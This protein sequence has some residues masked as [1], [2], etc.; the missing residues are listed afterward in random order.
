MTVLATA[1]LD[2]STLDDEA[3]YAFLRLLAPAGAE[4]TYR[5]VRNPYRVRRTRR[6]C[7]GR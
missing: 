2:G 4:T 6:L 7:W 3:I 1:E 5:T